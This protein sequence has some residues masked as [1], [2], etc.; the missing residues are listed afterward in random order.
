MDNMTIRC[1]N[2]YPV[3]SLASTKYVNIF[4][5]GH[6]LESK[7]KKFAC[8][9]DRIKYLAQPRHPVPKYNPPKVTRL[10]YNIP[11][12]RLDED[13]QLSTRIKMLSYPKVRKLI[14]AK[15]EYKDFID[16]DRL[17]RYDELIKESSMT[18]YSRLANVHLPEKRQS[19][20]KK[21]T[22]EDWE[23]HCEWLRKRSCPKEVKEY[24]PEPRYF[25]PLDDLQDSINN[26]SQPKK[27]RIREKYLPEVDR[28]RYCIYRPGE[29]RGAKY[30]SEPPERIMK[31]AKP[32]CLKEEEDDDDFQPF[33]VN[34]NA[35]KYQI[36]D[37]IN[38][39][40]M[41]KQYAKNETDTET[42]QFGVIKK[43][44][45]AKIRPRV[46]ELAV[47]KATNETEKP[48]LNASGS[49]VNPKALKAKPTPRILELAKP[50]KT[51]D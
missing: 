13:N 5:S 23:R 20:P 37:H 40:A 17:R 25:V 8:K 41:P 49:Q 44:L 33:S 30:L 10:R 21:W 26:L 35:L 11:I 39:L 34:P 28:C 48:T 7:N 3:R 9:S 1:G 18:M 31:L 32:K 15:N 29:K 22:K 14:S 27:V 42:T 12:V 46:N 43:A 6:L 38:T 2:V 36:T 47:P 19:M 50:R 24:L 45:E 51:F 16:H 4:G